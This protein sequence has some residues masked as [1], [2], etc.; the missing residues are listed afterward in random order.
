[1]RLFRV[2]TGCILAAPL[3]WAALAPAAFGL[4]PAKQI[5]QYPLR[6]WDDSD[7]LPQNSVIDITQTSDGYLWLGTLEGLVR[8]DGVR[9]VVFD[10]RTNPELTS[11]RMQVLEPDP[12]GYLLVGTENGGLLRFDGREFTPV[13]FPGRSPTGWSATSLQIDREGDIWVGTLIELLRLPAGGERLEVVLDDTNGVWQLFEDP[14]G[15]L[16]VGTNR[17]ILLGGRGG[18]ETL[19]LPPEIGTYPVRSF[20]IAG[21]DELW[22]SLWSSGGVLRLERPPGAGWDAAAVTRHLAGMTIIHVVRD[23]QGSL[24]MASEGAGLLR[25]SDRGLETL[26]T[27]RGYPSEYV[28]A[29]YED[30]E[31]NLW[32]GADSGGLCQLRDGKFTVLREAEGL[33]DDFVLSVLEDRRGDLWVGTYGA[34]LNR[35]RPDRW[36]LEVETYGLREGLPDLWVWSLL[37]ASDG[38]LWVGTYDGVV[39][40]RDGRVV[41]SLSESLFRGIWVRHLLEDSSG[42][43]WLATN[44]GLHRVDGRSVRRLDGI[45]EGETVMTLLEDSSGVLW[46][47]TRSGVFRLPLDGEAARPAWVQA[48]GRSTARG[49]HEDG[50]GRVWVGTEGFGLYVWDGG[51]V[52][53]LTGAEG[54]HDDLISSILEDGEGDLWLS[55]NKGIFRASKEELI[56]AASGGPPAGEVF[57]AADGMPSR[58][59]NGGSQPAGWKDSAGRLWF[60]TIKGLVGIDPSD[61][62]VNRV[63]PPVHVESVVVDG[64]ERFGAAGPLTL[65]PGR[66]AVRFDF[67]GLSLVA[68]ETVRFR[69]RLQGFD[70]EWMEEVGRRSAFY[71]NLPPGSY[72]FRV[73]AANDDGVWSAAEATFG[74]RQLPHFWQT[75]LFRLSAIVGV[76]LLG[77]AVSAWRMRALSRRAAQLE[78]TVAE[79]TRQLAREVE[80]TEEQAAKLRELDEVKSRFFANISHEFRTPLTLILGPLDG[81]LQGD[82]R[83]LGDRDRGELRRVRAAGR[84]LSRL[85]EQLL[86]ISKLAAGRVKLTAEPLDLAAFLGRLIDV[87]ASLAEAREV[88][89]TFDAAGAG[90][91]VAWC[92]AE[93]LETIVSN[94]LSNALKFT[95]A[96]GRVVVRLAVADGERARIEVEDSGVGI[97]GEEQA[98]LFDRFYQVART[99]TGGTGI[100]LSLVRD[101]V[102]L[103]RG[104][105][106][107]SSREG[108][109]TTF[110]VELPLG[111]EHLTDDD[112]APTAAAGGAGPTLA[113][114]RLEASVEAS[115]ERT[116]RTPRR[117]AE[118][119]AKATGPLVLVVDDHPGL[120]DFVRRGLEES[121]F[122]VAEAADGRS[123]L[124]AARELDPALI[125]SDVMMPEVDGFELCRRVK[126]DPEI[127]HIPVVLLTARAD[128]EDKLQGFEHGADAYLPK[129]FDQTELRVRVGNLIESRSRLRERYRRDGRLLPEEI[130]ATPLDQAFL[131]RLVA[132]LEERLADPGLD[133]TGLAREM[134]MSRRSL[135]RKLKALTGDTPH[136]LLQRFRLERADQLLQ[137]GAGNVGEVA[138]AVGYED[139]GTFTKAFRR[140]FDL[141][142]SER[143]ASSAGE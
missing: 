119:G 10:R 82:D 130:A 137:Q 73:A 40:L 126:A 32:T 107:V 140:R 18:F 39:R 26:G 105:I 92:D 113:N 54:L 33:S 68:P 85:I 141:A 96:G 114:A 13:P 101:L 19:D 30:R 31:G 2:P 15:M 49:M 78:T 50:E 95:P 118:H 47:G 91:L 142:P 5:S 90:S 21:P 131:E 124:E 36:P 58:E 11:Q 87:F 94:L 83:D 17:G 62:P 61:I 29:I 84:R 88:E 121:G 52:L 67:T 108:D 97:P 69:Y 1:M 133:V 115:A 106:G 55:S 37:D 41:E 79:R 134:A 143:L 81:M 102:E 72:T 42:T 111:R 136:E 74:L 80:K 98:K 56:A 28:L 70:E 45:P 103:H 7:G 112:L 60:P 57:D 128:P 110:T 75:N 25:F 14:D 135:Q 123:G 93:K 104:R 4:D 99:D 138:L 6:V 59:C 127:D 44:H 116:P 22:V 48:M 43:I 66:H 77:V 120:R 139:P 122:R 23:R 20:E 8:F 35:L 63:P 46:I 65:E 100:G 53:H 12:A 86:G 27:D 132:T 24:W 117:G 76:L 89:L 16:W 71:T 125:L 129:P 9:F 38:T 34:G 3:L 51:D 64:V 109:G